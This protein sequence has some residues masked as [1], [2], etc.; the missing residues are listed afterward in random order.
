[1]GET[2]EGVE[3]VGERGVISSVTKDRTLMISYFIP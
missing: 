2:G 3:G 1:M